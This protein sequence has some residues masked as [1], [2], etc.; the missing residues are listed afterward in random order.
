MRLALCINLMTFHISS[1]TRAY[2]II[3]LKNLITLSVKRQNMF[4]P[5]DEVAGRV[6]FVVAKR[7]KF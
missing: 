4:E 2:K 1:I 6:Y 5:R 7:I 3:A